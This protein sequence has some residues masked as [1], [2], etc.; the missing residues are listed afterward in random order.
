MNSNKNITRIFLFLCC[1]F[2]SLLVKAQNGS[3]SGSAIYSRNGKPCTSKIIELS[4]TSSRS[5]WQKSAHT[6][7]SGHYFYKDLKPSVYLIKCFESLDN[8]F[9]DTITVTAGNELVHNFSVTRKYS[10]FPPIVL[11]V[12]IHQGWRTMGELSVGTCLGWKTHDLAAY[13]WYSLTLGTEFNFNPHH[14]IIGPKITY[15]RQMGFLLGGLDWG[16]SLIYYTDFDKG[17]LYINPQVGI[18]I[19]TF[20]GLHLGYNIPLYSQ[21]GDNPMRSLVNHFTVSLIFS[22]INHDKLFDSE[23]K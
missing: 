21:S 4:D 18:N 3:I 2:F 12:G 1:A 10:T 16:C 23:K 9:T 22:I 6:D 17:E 5:S 19:I 7:S 8:V 14:F 13:K 15:N 20:L 11:N